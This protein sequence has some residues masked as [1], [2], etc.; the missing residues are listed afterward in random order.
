MRFCLIG[1]LCLFG[2]TREMQRKALDT[3]ISLNMG[4]FEEPGGWGG[5]GVRLPAA[6][7]V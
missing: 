2:T 6:W 4:R 3:V 7:R 5:G 1:R